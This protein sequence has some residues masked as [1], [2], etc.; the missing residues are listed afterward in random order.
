MHFV[1]IYDDVA[2]DEVDGAAEEAEQSKESCWWGDD[3]HDVDVD[4]DDDYIQR[5]WERV[6]GDE[7]IVTIF[8]E[9]E[10]EAR[11]GEDSFAEH[12]RPPWDGRV[13]HWCLQWKS[14]HPGEFWFDQWTICLRKSSRDQMIRGP[15]ER[16]KEL[17]NV[18]GDKSNKNK[19]NWDNMD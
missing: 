19:M 2:E 13:G 9:G 15:F 1:G 7:L 8:V 17:S 11:R 16:G 6:F 5:S 18:L 10:R 4:Q 14:F 3:V 12:G